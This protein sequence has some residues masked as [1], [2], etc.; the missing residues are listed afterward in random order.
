MAARSKGGKTHGFESK[1]QMRMC[2]ELAGHGKAGSWDCKTW[3]H[4]DNMYSSQ[5]VKSAYDALPGHIAGSV[6]GSKKKR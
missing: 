3:A 1:A 5:R 2:Y 6:T 4:R